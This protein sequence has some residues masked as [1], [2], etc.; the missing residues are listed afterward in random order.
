MSRKNDT[1]SAEQPSRNGKKSDTKLSKKWTSAVGLIIVFG[2]EFVLRDFL[3]PENASN[4]SIGL[5]IVGE[6]GDILFFGFSLD[7]QS[8]EEEHGKHRFGK[9]QTKTLSMGR[10]HLSSGAGCIFL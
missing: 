2:I 1:A 3:L 10:S 4:I 7:S 8:R 6:L 5:A 9:I